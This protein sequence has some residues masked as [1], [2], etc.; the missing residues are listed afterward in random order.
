MKLLS[1]SLIV[2]SLLSCQAG[3]PTSS[4]ETLPYVDSLPG[5]QKKNTVTN[6]KTDP[7]INPLE[8]PF[9]G[10]L[11]ISAS[12]TD[13]NGS[14]TLIISG[15]DAVNDE[16]A[17]LFAYLYV[18]QAGKTEKLWQIT[19]F[20]NG[21]CDRDIYLV[22]NSLEIVDLDEDG[23]AENLFMYILADNCDASPVS[24]KLMMHSGE[25]KLVIR[26]LTKTFLLPT[27]EVMAEAKKP[28]PAFDLAK[29]IFKVYASGK[30]DA[31][32]EKETNEF[33]SAMG[34]EN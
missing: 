11:R 18:T 4:E 7:K 29:P 30:W 3:N 22:P 19:D 13:K 26:G 2:F 24:T 23:I 25:T 16:N 20:V 27:P 17:E 6:I 14:N 15:K 5:A 32:V 12:W 1:L 9:Q 8:T 33:H 10:E 34:T 28:D 21:P 31:Y